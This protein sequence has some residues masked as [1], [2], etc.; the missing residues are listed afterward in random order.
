MTMR[1]RYESLAWVAR[2]LS[3]AARL[4]ILSRSAVRARMPGRSSC[5][6]AACQ[7]EPTSRSASRAGGATDFS[8][9]CRR[10]ADE[11]SSARA[12]PKG[13]GAS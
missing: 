7:S 4:P 12:A 3:E 1:M 6:E 11:T 13:G 9:A 5:E 10:L 2:F 8:T